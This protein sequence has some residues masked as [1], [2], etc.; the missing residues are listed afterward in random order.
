MKGNWALMHAYAKVHDYSVVIKPNHGTG[1][2]DVNHVQNA[3]ELEEA[4]HELFKSHRAICLSPFLDIEQEYRVIVLDESC[5]LIYSKQ[6]PQVVG[7]GHSSVIELIEKLEM[8]GAYTQK[9]AAGAVES[10]QGNLKLVPEEGQ[11]VL[12]G[13]KHNLGEGALPQVIEAGELHNEL[14]GLAKSAQSATNIRFASIDIVQT[15]GEHLVLEINSGVMMESFAQNLADGR[16]IA[17]GIYNRA[18][19]RMFAE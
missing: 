18:V 9:V 15:G 12:L 4:V 7:D 10:L 19:A 8:T 2:A 6:R 1:G 13:W 16:E 11:R 3:I 17:K 5:E 14:C